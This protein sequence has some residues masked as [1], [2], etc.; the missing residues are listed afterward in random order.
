MKKIIFIILFVF[1]A[2]TAKAQKDTT[3]LSSNPARITVDMESYVNKKGET[4]AQYWVI[5]KGEMYA[6]NKST[7]ERANL[8][9]RFD[10]QPLYVLISDKRSKAQRIVI[11]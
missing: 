10:Y 7:Y 4:K 2:M 3:V 1:V 8:Y 11:L 5:Y 9:K 6:S